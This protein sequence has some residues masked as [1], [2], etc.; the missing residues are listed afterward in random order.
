MNAKEEDLAP[1]GNT[2]RRGRERRSG[3][4]WRLTWGRWLTPPS[5]VGPRKGR[6]EKKETRVLS[7][8]DCNDEEAKENEEEVEEEKETGQREM[9]DERP[10]G[11]E[12]VESEFK[13]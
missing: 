1:K 13:T 12:E 4:E 9:T 11:L 8:A 10:P 2:Q 3:S 5:H 6:K 7:W